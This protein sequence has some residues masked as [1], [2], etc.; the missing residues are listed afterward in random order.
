MSIAV[1]YQTLPLEKDLFKGY[2]LETIHA[3]FFED[4]M[5]GNA[6]EDGYAYMAFVRQELPVTDDLQVVFFQHLGAIVAVGMLIDVDLYD[7]PDDEGFVG[8]YVFNASSLVTFKPV[9]ADALRKCFPKAQ[10]LGQKPQTLD[11]AGFDAFVDLVRPVLLNIDSEDFAPQE[12]I[13]DQLAA[14]EEEG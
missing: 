1:K 9:A 3:K 2:P 6:D 7:A 11:G 5:I 4:D 13:R 8:H 14:L 10:A 12:W